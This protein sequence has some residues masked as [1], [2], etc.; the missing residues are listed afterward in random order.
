M[1]DTAETADIGKLQDIG[2]TNEVE[3]TS[4][5]GERKTR[6][7]DI[8]PISSLSLPISGFV[9]TNPGVFLY[10]TGVFD[11]DKGR[12]CSLGEDGFEVPFHLRADLVQGLGRV[13]FEAEDQ[14]RLGV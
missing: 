5:N 3:R 13:G 12:R 11:S 1:T 7:S 6:E 4:D 10:Q 9:S 14:D 8:R 2:E